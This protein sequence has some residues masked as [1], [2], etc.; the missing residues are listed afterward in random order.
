M[1][2]HPFVLEIDPFNMDLRCLHLIETIDTERSS[3]S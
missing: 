2:L 1:D 3:T